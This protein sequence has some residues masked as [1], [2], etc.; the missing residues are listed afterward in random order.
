MPVY[1]IDDIKKRV[2]EGALPQPPPPKPEAGV[3]Y[4]ISP[5]T[6][7]VSSAINIPNISTFKPTGIPTTPPV[8]IPLYSAERNKMLSK[9]MSWMDTVMSEMMRPDFYAGRKRA[10]ASALGPLVSLAHYAMDP[11]AAYHASA[12]ERQYALAP[13]QA[14]GTAA[15]GIASFLSSTMHALQTARK[16]AP[17]I[18]TEAFNEFLSGLE[19]GLLEEFGDFLTT[20][21]EE[22]Q[23]AAQKKEG[24][25]I[26]E[27]ITGES[28]EI[29]E[30]RR[31]LT[32]TA[33]LGN[34]SVFGGGGG[35]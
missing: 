34:S 8:A 32:E 31:I 6:H 10:M 30:L 7:G 12:E 16:L 3:T 17:G 19:S 1:S 25:S 9:A 27:Q 14:L 28:P 26:L 11:T 18:G 35:W 22:R 21:E 24:R 13:Y 5:E 2:Q 20:E 15:P 33:A 29:E 4:K 23:L